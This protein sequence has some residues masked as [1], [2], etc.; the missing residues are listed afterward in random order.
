M[1]LQQLNSRRYIVQTA[2]FVVLIGIQTHYS[3]ESTAQ[4]SDA[5][6]ARLVAQI[7]VDESQITPDQF[8]D[9]EA[10]KRAVS[11]Q[12][13][14]VERFML[15]Q[16]S[17]S[18]GQAWL[19][20][21][22]LDPLSEAL[23]SDSLADV[24]QT[25]MDARF[26]LI[27]NIDGLELDVLTRL[28]S[29]IESLLSAIRFR[30]GEKSAEQLRK[31]LDSLAKRIEA[32]DSIPSAEDA[33][34][35]SALVGLLE[36]SQQSR[37]AVSAIRDVFGRPN[38]A[39]FV[40]EQAVQLA[41]NRQVD[42]SRP[43][44]DCILGTRIIGDAHT[45]GFVTATLLPSVGAARIQVS[46]DGNVSTKSTGFNGPVRLRTLG[47]A[48]ISATR[49][50]NLNE[51]GVTMDPAYATVSLNTEITAI[52]H[53]LKLVRRIASKRAAEQKPKADRIAVSRMQKQVG[54]EFA[55]QTSEAGG[56]EPPNIS[57]RIAPTL[58]RLSLV[59][60]ARLWGST[61][62]TIYIDSTLRRNDQISTT[63]ARPAIS[64][65]YEAAIQIQESVVDNALGPF[66]AG[67]TVNEA[68]INDLLAESGRPVEKKEGE[69]AEPPFEIDFARLQPI[70]FE[71]REGAIRLGI[72]G[73]RFA[74]G[75]R[76]LKVPM[77]ITATYRPAK[78][79]EGH[80][81]LIRDADVNVD[82]P[83]RKRLSV[84][85]AGLKR[86]IQN[87]FDEVFPDSLLHRAIEVPATVEIEAIRGREYHAHHIDSR[88]G[89]LTIA[90]R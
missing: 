26:R 21:L 31:Q 35:L 33:A 38:L 80:A 45:S 28:R 71:A 19:E 69:D 25:A 47:N 50:L 56:L 73:T 34:A 4:L 9:L 58:R 63:V 60:P 23:Q 37:A 30:D 17:L 55:Q 20:Y 81:I 75:E 64:S 8:P 22:A 57:E 3:S 46:L 68:M 67:R 49:T 65:S 48:Q 14:S 70:V 59:D 32:M 78:T 12:I 18:N 72:R 13:D 41:V 16:Q 11:E 85:Q 7:R 10:A 66:L 87:R 27:G 36:E 84:S 42:R 43:I 6:R 24:A 79:P 76:E 83:G 88:D 40:G 44:R 52:E 89:W 5:D 62:E 51:S 90:V 77:E 39:V 54:Q 86:T 74:Q 82:F 61:E 15:A 53:K 29:S 1:G 2:F